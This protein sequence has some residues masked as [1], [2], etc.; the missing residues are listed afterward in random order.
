VGGYFGWVIDKI[1][2]MFYNKPV[3]QNLLEGIFMKATFGHVLMHIDK[4]NIS[5]Y[6][7][8]FT[9]MNW[10]L[11]CDQPE[12]LG[13]GDANGGS[14]WF[15]QA[16]HAVSNDYDGVGMNHLAISVSEQNNVDEMVAYLQ[17][18]NIPALF[19]TPR[20]RPEFCGSPDQTYYQVMFESPDRILFEV[21]Y[22]GIKS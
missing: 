4:K 9:A 13:V 16:P 1:E 10:S 8:L 7:D 20:H 22:T 15:G 3:H 5:F 12:M 21:V 19:E 6:K 14:L 2:Q 18:H 11:W 17:A